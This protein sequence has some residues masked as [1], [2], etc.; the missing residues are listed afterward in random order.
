MHKQQFS[1][2]WEGVKVGSN[3]GTILG[4]AQ[5]A[6]FGVTPLYMP[7]NPMYTNFEKHFPCGIHV[8]LDI[9]GM[10]EGRA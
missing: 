8:V 5:G 10:T 1:S 9:V 4:I 3:V 7:L 6:N 2:A